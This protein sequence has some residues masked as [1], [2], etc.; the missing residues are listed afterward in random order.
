[1]PPPTTFPVKTPNV[2]AIICSGSR[3]TA[4]HRHVYTG[5]IG[6][7]GPL[8]PRKLYRWEWRCDHCGRRVTIGGW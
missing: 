3:T 5:E 8:A 7:S 2:V 6:Y 1:M 4:T